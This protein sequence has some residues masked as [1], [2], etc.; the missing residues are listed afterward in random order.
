MRLPAVRTLRGALASLL[1][2]LVVTPALAQDFTRYPL[3]DPA[4]AKPGS[5]FAEVTGLV[6][7]NPS[8]EAEEARALGGPD[9]VAEVVNITTT[10]TGDTLARETLRGVGAVRTS[11]LNIYALRALFKDD[12]AEFQAQVTASRQVVSLPDGGQRSLPVLYAWRVQRSLARAAARALVSRPGGTSLAGSYVAKVDGTECPLSAGNVEVKQQGRAV[13]MVRDGA[14]L[15]GGMVGDR[16]ASF[17]PNEQR[18]MTVIRGADSMR[19]EAPDR[20]LELYT[21]P[22]GGSELV[23]KG[24][25]LNLCT[26]TLTRAR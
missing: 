16:E 20:A 25:K 23:I 9:K 8:W 4:D 5:F 3:G 24:T 13:E 15:F 11:V 7:P 14:L 17:L 22:L 12:E 1:A 10:M 21:A 6:V 18:Y 19:F 26:V 2:I